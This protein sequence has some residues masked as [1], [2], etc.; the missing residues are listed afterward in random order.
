MQSDIVIVGGGAGGLELAC[1]LGRKLGPDKVTLVD[2]RLYHVWKPSLH[3]VAAG[4]L[5]IHQEGLSYQMLA[6]DRGFSFVYGA[7]TALDAAARHITI[8]PV[9]APGDGEEVLPERTLGYRSLVIAVGST[10]NYFGVPGAQEHT[11]SLNATEDAE[12]FRLRLLRLLAQAEQQKEDGATESGLDIVIIGGGATGVELAAELREASGAYAA[13]GFRR[14][15]V[16]RD[17]RITLLEGASRILAPLPERV[18]TA[19]ARLLD[20]RAI[21]VVPDCRVSRID[22][23]QVSDNQGNVYPADLCVWAA[24]I[25]APEFLGSLGLPLAKGGQIEVDAHLRVPGV[26]GVYALGDCAACTD[27]NGTHV[28]PRAQAAHQQADYLVKEFVG[29]AAGRPPQ[30]DPYVYRDYGSLVS[31]GRETTVGNLMGSLRGASLFVEGFMA[32]IMYMSLHLMHHQAVLGA[33]RTGLM[34]MGRFL[35][36]RT[37]PLVKLH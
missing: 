9:T 6:H 2:S 33:L 4:T 14:L 32:R 1:K 20:Q 24:G 18:S 19:A 37:T 29:E 31:I 30:K 10:S 25:R 27:G 12:R 15:H 3:E 28:P 8:A 22:K 21:R 23:K 16:Q 5:D 35:I 11:I 26:E 13:Y 17:V 34:V 36:R 7:M